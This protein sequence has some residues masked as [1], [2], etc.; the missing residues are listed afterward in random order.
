L[1]VRHNY[2]NLQHVLLCRA[3][4]VINLLGITVTLQVLTEK[5]LQNKHSD[6]VGFLK[7]GPYV[8]ALSLLQNISYRSTTNH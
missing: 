1:I 4:R 5:T 3:L 8:T 6:A 7:E 2:C